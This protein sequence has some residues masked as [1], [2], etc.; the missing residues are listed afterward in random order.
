MIENISQKRT[1]SFLTLCPCCFFDF[2]FV[3]CLCLK[4]LSS[5]V[6]SSG[7]WGV[8]SLCLGK[9][10]NVPAAASGRRMIHIWT[11]SCVFPTAFVGAYKKVL[12]CGSGKEI[13]CPWT[14]D[15][16]G[17]SLLAGLKGKDVHP[18]LKEEWGAV[19][20]KLHHRNHRKLG[21]GGEWRHSP[22]DFIC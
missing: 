1:I 12:E 17:K 5:V 11:G 4:E 20:R 7:P 3:L 6:T 13:A 18:R 2:F 19:L 21:G 14:E 16:S 8:D 10:H 22:L 15:Q 9:S